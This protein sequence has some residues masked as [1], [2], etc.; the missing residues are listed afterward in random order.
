MVLDRGLCFQ[1][2]LGPQRRG[3]ADMD[4][5]FILVSGF[6]LILGPQLCGIAGIDLDSMDYGVSPTH[7]LEEAYGDLVAAREDGCACWS[8]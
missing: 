8:A 3:I 7:A 5:G 1:L 6:Q 4:A 2:V